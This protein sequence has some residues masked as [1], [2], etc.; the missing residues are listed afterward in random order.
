MNNRDYYNRKTAGSAGFMSFEIPRFLISGESPAYAEI[1]RISN[2][3]KVLYALFLDRMNTNEMSTAFL[4]KPWHNDK[5]LTVKLHGGYD[6]QD[7][8]YIHFN[9]AEIAEKL[10]LTKERATEVLAE[11]E[12]HALVEILPPLGYEPAKIYPLAPKTA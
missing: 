10:T 9:T 1:S 3:A 6:E 12:E 5:N 2:N 7:R 11:L 8:A 4:E